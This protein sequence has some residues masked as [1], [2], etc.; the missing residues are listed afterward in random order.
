MLTRLDSGDV[1][2]PITTVSTVKSVSTPVV[3]GEMRQVREKLVPAKRVE[4]RLRRNISGKGAG[5]E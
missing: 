3:F 4:L 2:G 1:P 5:T